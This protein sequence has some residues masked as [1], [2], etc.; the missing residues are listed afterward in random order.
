MANR[1]GSYPVSVHPGIPNLPETPKGWKREPLGKYL[2]E[3]KRPLKMVDEELYQLVT[4]KRN[5]GGVVERE[6]L[7]G[8]EIKVKSQFNVK[9]GDFLISKR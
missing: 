8:K 5:R 9:G 2:K 3:I 4:V 1:N 7:L 6:K